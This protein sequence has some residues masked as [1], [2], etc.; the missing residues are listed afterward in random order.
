MSLLKI[1]N[2][3]N[4]KQLIPILVGVLV[5]AGFALG[6]QVVNNITHKNDTALAGL[7]PQQYGLCGY[8]VGNYGTGDCGVVEIKNPDIASLA[9][10]PT[11]VVVGGSTNCTITLT[12]GT[13]VA[14]LKGSFDV[15]I[16]TSGVVMTCAVPST[17]TIATTIDCPAVAVGNIATGSTPLVSQVKATTETAFKTGNS[18]TVIDP[19]ANTDIASVA[20][21]SPK[22]TGDTTNC[23]VTLAS[24]AGVPIKFGDLT[25]D[26]KLRISNGTETPCPTFASVSTVSTMTCVIPVGSILGLFVPTINLT[27]TFVTVASNPAVQVNNPITPTNITSIACVTPKNITE[28]TN[29]VVT[30]SGTTKFGDLTGDIKLSISNGAETACPAFSTAT[31]SNTL[32]CVIPVGTATGSFTPI[33]KLSGTAATVGTNNAVIVNNPTTPAA[34]SD[35]SAL[36]CTS[37]SANSTTTCTYSLP[38]NK[39]LPTDLKLSIGNG[40]I[41]QASGTAQS[42]TLVTTTVTCNNVPTGN[43]VGNQLVYAQTSTANSKVSTT[44]TVNI[45]GVNFAKADWV[46][47]PDQGGAA[48]L[49]KSPNSTSITIKNLKTVFDAAPSSNTRYTCNLEYRAIDDRNSTTSQWNAISNTPVAYDTT[50]GCTFNITKAMRLNNLNFSLRLTITDTTISNPTAINPNTFILNNE[51][52]FRFEGAGLSA[53]G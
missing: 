32:T 15:K 39:T 22:N 29:C 25:G 4:K 53:A 31:T 5:V 7:A 48:L 37:T 44:K 13:T 33:V 45:T 6:Y 28:N 43:S 12:T 1:K 50:A 17:A 23:V 52:I 26:I 42:C 16:G 20:C 51:Y 2:F 41:N 11:T 9:C 8:G 10:A 36:T 47:N 46:F 27:N 30:L 21:V 40:P 38:T 49:F 35:I 34:I 19:I 14:N 3:W 24:I 18:I